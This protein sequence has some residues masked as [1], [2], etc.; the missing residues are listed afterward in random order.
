[1]NIRFISEV[2]FHFFYFVIFL[3]NFRFIY[4]NKNEN[5]SKVIVSVVVAI[6]YL[7]ILIYYNF[8][9]YYFHVKVEASTVVMYIVV[10][11][12][13]LILQIIIVLYFKYGCDGGFG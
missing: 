6:I 12:I 13:L 10:G 1:M 8:K 9:K 3:A 5:Q 7:F 4:T 2:V 11:F